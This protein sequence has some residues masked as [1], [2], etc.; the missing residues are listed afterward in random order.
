[1]ASSVDSLV[2]SSSALRPKASSWSPWRWCGWVHSQIFCAKIF[3]ILHNLDW[4]VQQEEN[5]QE[6]PLATLLIWLCGRECYVTLSHSS[7]AGPEGALGEALQRLELTSLL[8]WTRQ[9]HVVGTSRSNGLGGPQRRQDWTC[10]ARRNQPSWQC[11]WNYSWWFVRSSRP[12]YHP[13]IG[14]CWECKEG[15]CF[16]VQSEYW[17]R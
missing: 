2:R 4:I 7:I 16:V 17:M 11:T 12:Q 8:P 9:L 1:M 5:I 6:R 13:W 3:A 15:D 10:H 14:C